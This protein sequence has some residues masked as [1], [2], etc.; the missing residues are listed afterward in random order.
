MTEKEDD[1]IIGLTIKMLREKKDLSQAQFAL[2]CLKSRQQMYEWEEG[3]KSPSP[4]NLLIIATELGITR[5]QFFQIVESGE[6]K[7]FVFKPGRAKKN[8]SDLL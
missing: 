6:A 1:N 5:S 3:T 4:Y 8:N 2:N 7:T